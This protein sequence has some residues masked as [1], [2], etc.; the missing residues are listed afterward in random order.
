MSR[1][2]IVDFKSEPDCHTPLPDP[3]NDW[4]RQLWADARID[5]PIEIV[6]SFSSEQSDDHSGRGTDRSR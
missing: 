2:R 6:S 5:D 1:S 3:F 4:D